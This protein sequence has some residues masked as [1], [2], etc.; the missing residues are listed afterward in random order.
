VGAG[1]V[2][3]AASSG[4]PASSVAVVPAPPVVPAVPAVP[5]VPAMLDLPAVPVIERP[6]LPAAGVPAAAPPPPAASVPELPATGPEGAE[7]SPLQAARDESV[8]QTVSANRVAPG[9]LTRDRG[10]TS[11]D[12]TRSLARTYTGELR[13]PELRQ[14][15]L[16][17]RVAKSAQ[18]IA[19]RAP[20][21]AEC[22]F[23]KT[24]FGDALDT[25]DVRI[26]ASLGRRSWSPFGHRISLVREHFRERDAGSEI[27]LEDPQSASVFAHEAMHVWQR[28][29]GRR[30]TWEA[31]PLQAA[32]TLGRFNPYA[33]DA[34]DD[35][36]VMLERFLGGNVEQQ[37]KMLEDFVY[38][39][40]IGADTSALSGVARH[41]R[42]R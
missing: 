7:S 37:A 39:E 10:L 38:R 13:C 31:I 4:V 1:G 8:Q 22:A 32:Y 20:S 23:L 9:I 17:Q 5:G 14:S 11:N 18:W 12:M 36:D 2:P 30:V 24:Y 35:P 28:Q 16:R 15:A 42:E 34:C 26:V 25:R 41:V 33:Y 21:E 19:G 29:G 27:V 40:R 3:V 6:P